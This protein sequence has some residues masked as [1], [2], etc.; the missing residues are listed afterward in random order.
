MLFVCGMLQVNFIFF[1]KKSKFIKGFSEKTD[2]AYK[3]SGNLI[4][5]SVCNIRTV[6]S[7]GNQENILAV[8]FLFI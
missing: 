7:F 5:E 4:M 2:S 6:L 3:D 1:N 8:Y